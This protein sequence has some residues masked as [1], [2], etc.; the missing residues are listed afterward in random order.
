MNRPLKYDP[1]AQAHRHWTEHG[2]GT[3]AEG[4]AAVTSLFRSQ[5]IF[6]ARIDTV[7]RPLGLTFARFEMLTLLAFTKTGTLPMAKA[8]ARLQVHPTSVTNT[9]DRL[10]RA[11]LVN[12]EAHPEDGRTTLVQITPAGRSTSE[13]AATE[14][15]E[16]VFRQVGIP[17]AD[18]AEINRILA[19]FRFD[20]GDF[21]G[22]TSLAPVESDA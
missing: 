16:R 20:A 5:Q 7:L 15:N 13:R 19:R 6:M 4:M 18:V 9:V 22:S 2:W 17:A 3:A 11:G 21:T 8:S 12:R 1:V 10:E 14:L